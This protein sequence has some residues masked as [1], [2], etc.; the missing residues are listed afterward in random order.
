AFR[1]IV[2]DLYDHTC[3]ACGL[4]VKL[5]DGFSLM[6]PL[7]SSPSGSLGTTDP[8]MVWHSA[9]ITTALWTSFSS[10]R[11]PTRLTKQES[12]ASARGSTRGGT[13]K[14]TSSAYPASLSWSRRKRNS[15]RLGNVWSGGKSI[16]PGNN[17]PANGSP[18]SHRT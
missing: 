5:Q 6:A 7:T 10:R 9:P 16:S 12:G 1:N 14:K 13:A 2:L 17:H 4:R 3:T 11:A 18:R 8:T 15:I